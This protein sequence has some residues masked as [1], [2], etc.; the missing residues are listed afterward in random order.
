MNCGLTVA[1][2]QKLCDY[3]CN[4]EDDDDGDAKEWTV[5]AMGVMLMPQITEVLVIRC[6]VFFLIFS[7]SFLYN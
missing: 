2:K 3:G 7:V 4:D 1:N 6:N 5:V